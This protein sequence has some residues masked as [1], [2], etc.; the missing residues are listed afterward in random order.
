[1]IAVHVSEVDITPLPLLH[2]LIDP[3][4]L[5]RLLGGKLIEN[6]GFDPPPERSGRGVGANEDVL[7]IGLTGPA[8]G[9]ERHLLPEGQIERRG[10]RVPFLQPPAD[11]LRQRRRRGP[12]G[13]G[14]NRVL[15]SP[16]DLSPK[17]HPAEAVVPE[18][19][20]DFLKPDTARLQVIPGRGG[21]A[22]NL[23]GV[24]SEEKTP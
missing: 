2:L 22:Q 4:E 16:G 9:L 1:M 17:R 19:R 11:A 21:A 5:R 23:A 20:R 7:E 24:R 10:K 13:P 18:T 12:E 15:P 14:G 8:K 3:F 6:V